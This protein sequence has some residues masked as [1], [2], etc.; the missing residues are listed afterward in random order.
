MYIK[1]S[2]LLST[3]LIISTTICFSSTSTVA[4][5]IL[6]YNPNLGDSIISICNTIYGENDQ[7]C[8]DVSVTK[9]GGFKAEITLY[10]N[11]EIVLVF[12]QNYITIPIKPNQEIHV[13]IDAKEYWKS[14]NIPRK[15]K[16]TGDNEIT[17]QIVTDYRP[18]WLVEFYYHRFIDNNIMLHEL[19][20]I[21]YYDYK[22]KHLKDELRFL[23]NYIEENSITDT[24]FID[25][26][27]SNI[28]YE[29][30]YFMHQLHFIRSNPILDLIPDWYLDSIEQFLPLNKDG[31]INSKEYGNYLHY[32]KMSL[33]RA[34][35]NSDEGRKM[36]DKKLH[37]GEAK[38]KYLINHSEGLAKDIMLGKL[39]NEFLKFTKIEQI[40]K[41]L[42][43]IED[44]AIK[45]LIRTKIKS[46]KNGT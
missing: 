41:H 21:D 26:A 4:G 7:I 20:Y 34:F 35:E 16:I 23:E 30:G 5:Q 31:A 38:I 19:D 6:N 12:N 15:V 24:F 27:K 44:E 45:G 22:T 10:R 18:K 11:T 42:D 14:R 9:T 3:W 8:N 33:S 46:M 37:V 13:Q 25:W 17:Y 29:Y 39:L 43:A 1:K 40:E 32:K 2:L 28:V 36:I